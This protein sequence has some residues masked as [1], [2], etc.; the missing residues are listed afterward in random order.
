[1]ADTNTHP[2]P[3]GG[4]Y[5]GMP[6]TAIHAESDTWVEDEAITY[7]RGGMTRRCYAVCP[8]GKRRVVRCG[9]ANTFFSLPAV[10]RLD[11]KLVKGIVVLSE[12]KFTFTSKDWP[13]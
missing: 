10:C 2:K 11:G 8:D 3:R 13:K 12:G 6:L 5:L 9:P 4:N 7:P 1:M